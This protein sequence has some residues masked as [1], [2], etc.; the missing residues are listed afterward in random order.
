M[1]RYII[2]GLVTMLSFT[3]ISVTAQRRGGDSSNSSR[4]TTTSGLRSSSSS[5]NNNS[6][7]VRSSSTTQTR[8]TGNVRTSSSNSRESKTNVRT[9]PNQR[10]TN[11]ISSSSSNYRVEHKPMENPIKV[12]PKKMKTYP[13]HKVTTVVHHY[14]RT[15]TT[16]HNHKHI[17]H[18][19]VNY[20]YLDGRYYTYRDN[21][22]VI[23][24][25]PRK[26]R[27]ATIPETFFTLLVKN[28]TYY[29]V[30]GAYYRYDDV[31]R[32]YEVVDPPMGAIVPELPEYD[33]NTVMLKGKTY[34]VY[35]NILY[36]PIVTAS[37]VQY[38]VVGTFGDNY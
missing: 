9:A 16:V 30:A 15:I 1:K 18:G 12:K 7:S 2:F 4:S 37:G 10:Q 21:A 25:P 13:S 36:K 23:V 33:V 8:S 11:T 34:L 22:Y 3:T 14:P 27:V 35:D 20:Y 31:L 38:E 26:I 19:G 28:L 5:V 6:S 32:T 24:P 29:Y 17:Y